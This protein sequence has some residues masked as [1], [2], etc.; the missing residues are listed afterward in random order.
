MKQVYAADDPLRAHIV[1]EFLEAEGIRAEVVGELLFPLRG[2]G[3]SMAALPE[4]W[5]IDGDEAPRARELIEERE[6]ANHQ[7]APLWVRCTGWVCLLC[8]LSAYLSNVLSAVLHAS[9]A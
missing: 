4:V 2:P 9:R 7:P 6:M 1:K 5:V 8:H 3:A